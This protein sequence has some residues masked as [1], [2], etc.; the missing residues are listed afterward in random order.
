MSLIALSRLSITGKL[1][2]STPII[3]LSEI[4]EAHGIRYT[5]N[6]FANETSIR[7]TIDE[8]H[9]FRVVTVRIPYT[10]EHY[11]YIA[12]YVNPTCDWTVE[13]LMEAF[14]FLQRYMG[15]SVDLPIGPFPLGPPTP[16]N[17]LSYNACILY[18]LCRHYGIRTSRY[19]TLEDMARAVSWLRHPL[20]EL[21]EMVVTQL[22]RLDKSNLINLLVT[23]AESGKIDLAEIG[24][25]STDVEMAPEPIV[26]EELENSYQSL[27]DVTTRWQRLSPR[28]KVEAIVLAAINY[29]IDLSP[30]ADPIREYSLLSTPPY[31]PRDSRLQ[32]RLRYRS[33]GLRLDLIFNP[34]LPAC[35]Y[36]EE[37]LRSMALREGFSHQD[38]ISSS[39]Y[40]LLGLAYVSNTFYSGR[41]EGML[42]NETPF[43]LDNVD[44]LDDSIIICFGSRA[45]GG[46]I[47]FRASEL[48]DRF[49][50]SRNF[51]NPMA[52]TYP[53][54][55]E[56]FETRAITKLKLIANTI[57]PGESQ[58]AV[59]ERQ[60]LARAILET[61][62]F[63]DENNRSAFMLYE[64]YTQLPEEIQEQVRHAFESLLHLAMYMRGWTGQG[65]Y[66]I[67][68]T[69]SINQNDV[70]VRV[71][72]GISQ[73]EDECHE[74]GSMGRLIWELPLLQYRSGIFMASTDGTQGLTLGDRINIVKQGDTVNNTNSCIRL[75]SN[76]FAA[77]VYRYLQV[78]GVTPPFD[79]DHLRSIS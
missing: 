38:L 6:H 54:M 48:A 76:W 57:R 2:D 67:R 24:P 53:F 77:S 30:A 72:Q 13:P 44:D 26:S 10:H 14:A 43:T 36:L 22:P 4:A 34:Q 65:P 46:M 66:P 55:G 35:L 64:T 27:R 18:K 9:R 63:N 11:R 17:R 62:L 25:K 73:F 20:N 19:S 16:Q 60:M 69:P 71:T 58:E 78:L 33:D 68:E 12:R 50:H 29:K 52:R 15:E 59:A 56:V 42:N 32:A 41:Q 40:E 47:A 21:S 74:L 79:I 5:P 28:N 70:D 61:E 23:A 1:N 37:D 7:H 3:V 45:D 31:I 8:I 49:T 75:S 51:T 39:P